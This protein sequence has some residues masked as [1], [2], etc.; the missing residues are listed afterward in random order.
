MNYV[1]TYVLAVTTANRKTYLQHAV[2]FAAVCK[3]HGA[4]SVVEYWRDDVPEGKLTSLP[5]A[6]QRSAKQTRQSFFHR[7]AGLKRRAQR[8]YERRN[9]RPAAERCRDAV[10][11]ESG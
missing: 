4:L 11:M 6:V 3:E 8:W 5:T 7:S 2:G 1:D 9:G 10:W